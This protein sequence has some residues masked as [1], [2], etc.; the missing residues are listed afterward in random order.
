VLEFINTIPETEQKPPFDLQ[1]WFAEIDAI[2]AE[3]YR[4][5]GEDYSI[6]VTALLNEVRE[7]ES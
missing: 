5:R 3:I 7:E 4:E 2:H 1:V 6:D